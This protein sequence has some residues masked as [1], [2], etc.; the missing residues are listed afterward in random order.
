MSTNL[1]NVLRK[2]KNVY[3]KM[4]IEGWEWEWL[5]S[6]ED[7]EFNNIKQ[8][9][10]ELHFFFNIPDKKNLHYSFMKRLKTIDNLNKYFFL[11]HVHGNNWSSSF[12][13]D[14]NDYPQV[15]ECTYINK[16]V[17]K[18]N[19]NLFVIRNLRSFPTELDIKNNMYLDD[20]NHLLNKE[21]FKTNKLELIKLI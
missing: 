14:N 20:I 3:V 9:S 10:I 1:K 12:K 15:I 17:F 7:E 6:L 19:S 13:V 16:N 4:D 5:D 8:M 21:P 11:M 18:N 2:Y